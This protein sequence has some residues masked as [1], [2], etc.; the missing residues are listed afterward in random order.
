MFIPI[1]PSNPQDIVNECAKR[2]FKQYV[3][4]TYS[5][6]SSVVAPRLHS[7]QNYIYTAKS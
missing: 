2:N 5:T 3:I 4:L 1:M 6:N 7:N